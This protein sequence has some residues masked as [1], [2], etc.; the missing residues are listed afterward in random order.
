MSEQRSS[1]HAIVFLGMAGFAI[2]MVL[3]MMSVGT[4]ESTAAGTRVKLAMAV[5]GQYKF[6]EATAE[7]R[8]AADGKEIFVRC[9]SREYVPRAD[10]EEQM[11]DVAR[12]VYAESLKYEDPE[13]YQ[14]QRVVVERREELGSGC[15]KDVSVNEISLELPRR[16]RKQKN[17]PPPAPEVPPEPP[18]EYDE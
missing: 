8:D 3:M 15:F 1:L 5:T 17:A 6:E 16:Q 12:F 4:L 11:R 7:F 13:L 14:T 18:P 2:I 10:Q 9:L